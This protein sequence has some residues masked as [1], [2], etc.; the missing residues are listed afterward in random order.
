MGVALLVH[1]PGLGGRGAVL[2]DVDGLLLGVAQ[3]AH[4]V[5]HRRHLGG[6]GGVRRVLGGD[7]GDLLLRGERL[8]HRAGRGL[9]VQLN[10]EVDHGGQNEHEQDDDHDKNA[11]HTARLAHVLGQLR[12][13]SGLLVHLARVLGMTPARGA[14]GLLR[15]MG[16]LTR[17]LGWRRIGHH[18]AEGHGVGH[19]RCVRGIGAVGIQ[20][21]TGVEVLEDRFIGKR[22]AGGQALVVEYFP[23][24]QVHLFEDALLVDDDILPDDGAVA[25]VHGGHG[26]GEAHPPTRG[27][28]PR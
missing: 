6:I 11:A 23:I 13:L 22:L 25:L 20:R 15:A 18:H 19:G 12:L 24:A 4:Q 7:G 5:G 17:R 2:Q 27:G 21:T 3:Q 9:L 1:R 16:G 14:V 26:R 8:L 28:R 10:A